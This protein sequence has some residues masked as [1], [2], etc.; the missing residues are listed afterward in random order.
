[1]PDTRAVIVRRA[2]KIYWSYH[3]LALGHCLHHRQH[4]HCQ[5]Q[6]LAAAAV[7]VVVAADGLLVA[8]VTMD[9]DYDYYV[10]DETLWSAFPDQ[11]SD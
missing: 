11:N 6:H 2:Y 9:D 3:R 8:A 1:M 10:M 5:P 4:C 7:V